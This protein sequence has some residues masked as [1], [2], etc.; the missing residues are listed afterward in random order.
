MIGRFYFDAGSGRMGIIYRDDEEDDR[1][2]HC[3]DTFQIEVNNEWRDVRIEHARDWYLIGLRSGDST[4]AKNYIGSK[5]R[6]YSR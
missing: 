5:V 2:L 3:G 4:T 1:E 6:T